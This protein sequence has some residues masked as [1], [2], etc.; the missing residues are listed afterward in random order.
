MESSECETSLRKRGNVRALT[1]TPEPASGPVLIAVQ[2]LTHV[3][4]V[5]AYKETEA[6]RDIFKFAQSYIASER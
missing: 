1:H 2:V 4:P 3:I 5:M 6:Q